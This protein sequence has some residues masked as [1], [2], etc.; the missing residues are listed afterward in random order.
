MKKEL[1]R[2]L[3]YIGKKE[4]Y[5]VWKRRNRTLKREDIWF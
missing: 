3:K 1:E 4:E 5:E 2:Q